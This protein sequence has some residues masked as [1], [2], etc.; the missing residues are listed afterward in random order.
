MP[1]IEADC[2]V[3]K[4]QNFKP[5]H[6]SVLGQDLV[7]TMSDGFLPPDKKIGTEA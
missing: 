7:Q 2:I 1:G 6:G 4:N 3:N 5:G